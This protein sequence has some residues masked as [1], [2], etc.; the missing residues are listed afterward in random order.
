[1]TLLIAT[2]NPAKLRRYR[3]ILGQFPGL[4]VLSPQDLGLDLSVAETGATAAE[5]AHLK[6]SAYAAAS[7]LPALGIDEALYIPALSPED[8][9]GVYVRRAHLADGGSLGDEELLGFFLETARRLPSDQREVQWLYAVCLALP[10][11]QA[12]WSD[13]SYWSAWLSEKPFLPYEPGYPLS[14]ILCDRI[15]GKPVRAMTVEEQNQREG[16]LT[17]AV[18][19]LVCQAFPEMSMAG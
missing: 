6:A 9:P 5:N 8:Q 13:Q 12:H 10:Y 17:A 2:R 16:P 15:T 14:A 1:M 18:V 7:G 4:E 3:A 19:R 11:D